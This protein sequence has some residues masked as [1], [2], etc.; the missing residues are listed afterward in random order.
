MFQIENLAK[1]RKIKSILSDEES[2]LS[3]NHFLLWNIWKLSNIYINIQNTD[4]KIL[5][6]DTFFYTAAK[7][8]Y[9]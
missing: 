6:T 2:N 5:S 3:L 7:E 9:H 1:D 4:I 8:E